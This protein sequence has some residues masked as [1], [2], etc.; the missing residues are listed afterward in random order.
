MKHLTDEALWALTDDSLSAAER[1]E[2][3]AHL[4]ECA[5]CRALLER[6]RR[7][8][9]AIDEAPRT[10][11][12][13]EDTW[14]EV[15]AR[16]GARPLALA[17]R[18]RAMTRSRWLGP[19]WLA[20]AA[21]LLVVLSS[22]VTAWVVGRDGPRPTAPTVAGEGPVPDERGVTPRFVATDEQERMER[23]LT[24]LL[25]AQRST[26]TPETV[27]KIERNLDVI[28]AAIDEIKTALAEDPNN[29]A[30]HDLL[31]ASYRQKAALLKQASQI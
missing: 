12:P 20:A 3:G 4:T 14:T 31:S 9:G 19:G 11:A 21:V 28:D 2:T 30:L 17:Q 16:I 18:R 10:M 22:M 29:R 1:R 24:A 8:R 13:P 15:R 26:L 6:A 27:A 5:E 25:E 7:L 23:E